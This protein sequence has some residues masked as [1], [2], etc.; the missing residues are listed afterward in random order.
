MELS[1]AG[2]ALPYATGR[3]ALIRR[4]IGSLLLSRLNSDGTPAPPGGGG[5]GAPR[6]FD[7]D[8][9]PPHLA[10]AL[11]LV[12]L[13]LTLRLAPPPPK[14]SADKAASAPAPQAGSKRKAS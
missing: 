12:E 3:S 5:K 9:G 7:A 6:R 13:S 2:H 10:D 11:K 14:K 4:A 8:I 1:C